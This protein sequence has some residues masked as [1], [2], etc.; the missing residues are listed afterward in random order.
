ME[1]LII[2]DKDFNKDTVCIVTGAA[3][4]I[5][6]ATDIAA[7]ANG[8]MVSCIDRDEVGIIETTRTINMAGGSAVFI[9]TDLTND[10][11][12]YHAVAQSA[13]FGKI[14][15]LCNIAG[16]QHID[17]IENFPM[18]TYDLMQ[19]IMVRAPFYLSQLCI[20]HMRKN[21][22][23][24]VANM[25]S[26]HA[27]ICTKNKPAYSM[28]K[29]ALRA[30]S[31]SISAEGVGN[32]RSFTVS[33]GFVK[34]PL[35]MD[36]VAAQAKQRGITEEQVVTDVMLGRSQVKELMTAEEVANIIMFGLSRHGRYIVGG[37]ILADGG[38][39]LTY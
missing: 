21:G 26:I 29:F 19:Q 12:M 11:D 5:G 28:A 37:D 38:A 16:I 15:Y 31:Q 13:R 23:G 4:G 27:H 20:P 22:G 9:E 30:L 2:E 32:I 18:P 7:G 10:A 25:A 33:T 3:S 34:T 36:Q 35:A 8:L 39:V 1:N 14:K 6:R 24:V 17:S